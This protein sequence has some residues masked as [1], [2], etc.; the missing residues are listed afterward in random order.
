MT[1]RKFK[2]KFG[3]AEHKKYTATEW[4]KDAINSAPDYNDG[5]LES[6]EHKLD[7]LI[8]IVVIITKTLTE[9][10]ENQLMDSLSYVISKG[11]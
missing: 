3:F 10:Q 1:E 11:D 6:L 4:V 7:K 2:N 8:E 9:E 5:Q